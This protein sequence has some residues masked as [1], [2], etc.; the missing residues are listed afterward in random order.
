MR[1]ASREDPPFSGKKTSGSSSRHRAL[2]CQGMKWCMALSPQNH[3][4]VILKERTSVW[5]VA[6]LR[7]R[8]SRHRK[9]NPGDLRKAVQGFLGKKLLVNLV[10]DNGQRG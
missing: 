2:S 8:S 5:Q 9:N 1:L 7:S 6:I 3:I 4:G 10:D